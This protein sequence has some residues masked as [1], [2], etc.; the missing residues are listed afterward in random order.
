MCLICASRTTL[1]FFVFTKLDSTWV[2]YLELLTIT[3]VL[4]GKYSCHFHQGNATAQNSD[5]RWRAEHANVA[6]NFRPKTQIWLWSS[7][8]SGGLF[9]AKEQLSF[10]SAVISASRLCLWKPSKLESENCGKSIVGPAP[11]VDL[12]II[13]FSLGAD[14]L[15]GRRHHLPW[16]M[17]TFP[18]A[19]YTVCDLPFR[20]VVGIL[21]PLVK[22]QGNFPPLLRFHCL[23]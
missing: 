11:N 10:C 6:P 5:N 19:R 23:N 8:S 9:K 18:M 16:R 21:Q 4:N 17:G 20:R 14:T 2:L 3:P 1:W 22:L 12:I 13:F 15:N 7:M